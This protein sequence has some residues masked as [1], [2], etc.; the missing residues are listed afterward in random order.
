MS[1]LPFAWLL[2]KDI[3]PLNME[4]PLSHHDGRSAWL[5]SGW[6]STHCQKGTCHSLRRWAEARGSPPLGSLCQADAPAPDSWFVSSKLAVKGESREGQ[7]PP[8]RPRRVGWGGGLV[9]AVLGSSRAF[10]A[11]E[12][13]LSPHQLLKR[14]GAFPS[15]GDQGRA[16]T[17]KPPIPRARPPGTGAGGGNQPCSIRVNESLPRPVY[18]GMQA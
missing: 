4:V 5:S 16:V 9:M 18:I 14:T 8:R 3:P 10:S 11:G 2:R 15:K 7:R 1:D 12:A 17:G 13:G 6:F